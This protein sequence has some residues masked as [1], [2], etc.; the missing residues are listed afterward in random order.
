[1]KKTFL[2]IAMGFCFMLSSCGNDTQP[3]NAEPVDTV[4]ANETTIQ[5]ENIDISQKTG[6]DLIIPVS[7]ITETAKFYPI[8]VDGTNMEVFAVKD[9]DGNIRTAYNTCQS[10]YT[11]GNGRY[12]TEGTDLVCQNCGFHFTA[13]QVGNEK[14]SGCSPW[15]ISPENRTDTDETITISYDFLQQSKNIFANWQ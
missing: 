7:E 15:A 13:D 5:E 8:T 3:A 11:S 14:N 10:C 12:E 9:S 6:E 2:L 4:T 1:M